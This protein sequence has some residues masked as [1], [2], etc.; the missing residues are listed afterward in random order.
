MTLLTF[1]SRTVA[2]VA[3]AA[4]R[5]L[6]SVRHFGDESFINLPL[7]YPGGSFVTVRVDRIATGFRVRT[8][9]SRIA[10][11]KALALSDHSRER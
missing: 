10:S 3:E 5:T 9:G 2:D 8:M 11:L 1:Q 7:I 4:A 6:I